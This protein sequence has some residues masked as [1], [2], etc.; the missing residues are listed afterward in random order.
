MIEMFIRIYIKVGSITSFLYMY[1]FLLV[2]VLLLTC[3]CITSYLYMYYFLL[4]H[5]LLL[6]CTC[7]TSNLYMYYFLLVHVLLLTFFK[8]NMFYFNKRFFGFLYKLL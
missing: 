6:T 5:V 8:L 1:Y 2:H 4:V 3:T 7:I